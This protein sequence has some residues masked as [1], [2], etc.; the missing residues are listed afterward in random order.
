MQVETR[1]RVSRCSECF[2]WL[3]KLCHTGVA[4]FCGEARDAGKV[5]ARRSNDT[6][7]AEAVAALFAANL[8]KR[9]EM[10]A[11]SQE[12]VAQRA[13]LSRYVYGKYEKGEGR[14]GQPVNPKMRTLIALARALETTV[15]ELIPE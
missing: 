15:G 14:P 2:V 8:R 10:L 12:A 6:E 7:A 9:R 11:L 13:G 5:S 1:D 3:W 4:V